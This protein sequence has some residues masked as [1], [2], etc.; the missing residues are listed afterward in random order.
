VRARRDLHAVILEL[1]H[2][3]SGDTESGWSFPVRNG[4]IGPRS[5]AHLIESVVGPHVNERQIAQWAIHNGE[6]TTLPPA[7][8]T[9]GVRYGISPRQAV[10]TIK[11]LGG[12]YGMDAELRFASIADLESE[13][14]HG[15][16]LLIELADAEPDAPTRFAELAALDVPAHTVSLER[17][18]ASGGGAAT[19]P[20]SALELAWSASNGAMIVTSGGQQAGPALL[21]VVIEAHLVGQA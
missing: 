1:T 9:A 11:A 15:R 16:V 21:P 17:P 7:G 6:V 10:T 18:G 14:H 12:Q 20:L 5:L 19:I 2:A 13:R 4:Q 8:E 3:M